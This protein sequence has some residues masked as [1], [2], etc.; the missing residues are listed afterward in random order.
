MD[1]GFNI[2]LRGP[3]A[4]TVAMKTLAKRGEALGFSYLAFPD[5]IVIPTNIDSRYPYSQTGEFPGRQSGDCL[6]QLTAMAYVAAVTSKIRLLTSVMVVPHRNP[7]HTARILETIDTLSN[8]RLTVGC[9]VGW[10]EEEFDAIGTPPFKERGKVTDEYL[11]VFKELWTKDKPEF[12]GDY[13]TFSDISF[14]PKPVQKPHPPLWIGGES[15][16]ALRRTARYGDAWYPIGA[17]PQHPLNTI[18]R[19]QAGVEK[20]EAECEKIG[21]DPKQ[22]ELAYL[23]NWYKENNTVMLDNGE[24]HLLTGSD[25][26]IVEDAQR[27][28]A[29]GVRHL[30]F[31]FQRATLEESLACMERFAGE[32]LPLIDK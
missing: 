30:L 13:A 25:Q 14:L 22:I 19:F 6:E 31:N 21:R 12:S 29:A 2:P 32:V 27:L 11:Q 4:N 20:L 10:L 24:R 15:G 7:V 23:G 18:G 1:Y 28:R 5:H 8:G 3:L 26:N 17:N 16:P 9:G